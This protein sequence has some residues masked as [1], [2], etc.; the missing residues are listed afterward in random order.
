METKKRRKITQD[1]CQIGFVGFSKN[2][3]KRVFGNGFVVAH[4]DD[5]F[6]SISSSKSSFM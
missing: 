4:H 2:D 5:F 6:V 3:F 1:M